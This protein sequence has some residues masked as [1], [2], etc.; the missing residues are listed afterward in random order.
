MARRLIWSPDAAGDLD[1]IIRFIERDSPKYASV[2]AR[3]IFIAVERTLLFP[4]MGRIVPQLSG[5]THREVL[6]Y[7]Y[8]IIYR[9]HSDEIHVFAIIHGARDLKT[10]IEGRK[11]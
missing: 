4:E 2:V 1:A 3:D 8:R 5:G 6:A 10:A 11:S 9:V 7:S